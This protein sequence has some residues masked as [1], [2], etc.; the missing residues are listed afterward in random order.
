MT[1]DL[2][3]YPSA[4]VSQTSKGSPVWRV[5]AGCMRDILVLYETDHIYVID[6][7]TCVFTF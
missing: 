4:L 7:L 2:L 1:F 5:T 3:Q 6:F